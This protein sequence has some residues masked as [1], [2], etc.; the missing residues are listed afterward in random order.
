MDVVAAKVAIAAATAAFE[1][2]AASAATTPMALG[3]F[4]IEPREE[5]RATE[6][7]MPAVPAVA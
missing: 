3:K 6:A 1:A 5:E 2:L 4:A 7:G